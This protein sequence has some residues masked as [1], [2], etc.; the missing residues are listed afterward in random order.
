MNNLD[1]QLKELYNKILSKSRYRTDRTGFGTKSIFGYQMRFNMQEGFPLTT[2]RK[3]HTKSL[4]HELLWFLGSYDE[5]YK[6]FGNTNIKYLLDHGVTFWTDWCYKNYYHEKL[7]KYQANDLKDSKTVKKFRFLS[8]K[9]F[10]K[11][12]IKDDDFAMKWGNLG[13]VY[14][15]QWT[16]WGGYYEL[17][18]K[19]NIIKETAGNHVLVDKLGWEKI[20]LKGINQINKAIDQIIE[21]PDSRRIIVNSWNVSDIDDM[22]LPPCHLLFQFYTDIITM[23]QRI[24]Y[25]EKTYKN[26]DINNYMS[27]HNIKDWDEIKRDPRKQIKILDHFNVPERTLDLQLYMRSSDQFLVAPYN[28][29]SYSLLLHMI[30]QVTNTIPNDF[31]L[32]TGDTHLYAN[33]IEATKELLKRDIRSLPKLKLNPDIQNIYGFRYEDIE[34]VDY[35]PHPNI[36][37]EVAV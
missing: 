7:K 11:K 9:D 19:K 17:V 33:S 21:N 32:T 6:K 18:E 34:I 29:A 2:L 27:K 37:V 31:I 3:I 30:A 5:K 16:D 22:L 25:C 14:G 26:E 10:E 12:I 1:T 28:I 23:E 35:D 13:P 8:Q 20:Y 36:K 15:K 24:D 4:V